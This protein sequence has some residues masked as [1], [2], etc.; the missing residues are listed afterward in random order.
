M[1][2]IIEQAKQ[3]LTEETKSFKGGRMETVVYKEV[4]KTLTGFCDDERF[5]S[6]IVES[7]KTLSDCCKT[8]L[9]DINGAGGG[10]S[11]I[12][13]YKRAVEFYFPTATVLFKMEI[14]LN[15]QE[16]LERKAAGKPSGNIVSLLDLI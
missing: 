4:A 10:I 5:A 7:K 15:A 14:R 8:V 16:E 6:A 12:E 9:S 1:S 11:D 3:K 2:E 13:T